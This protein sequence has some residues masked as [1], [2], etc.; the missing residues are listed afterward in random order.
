M[1]ADIR[2]LQNKIDKLNNSLNDV[3]IREIVA[4]EVLNTLKKVE[5]ITTNEDANNFKGNLLR[6]YPIV[7]S[8]FTSQE[9]GE[10]IDAIIE[11]GQRKLALEIA[12]DDFSIFKNASYGNQASI[13]IDSLHKQYSTGVENSV[14]KNFF[15]QYNS[16]N[17]FMENAERVAG[18]QPKKLVK[19]F[20]QDPQISSYYKNK[21]V[22]A[23]K[24]YKNNLPYNAKNIW[25]LVGAATISAPAMVLSGAGFAVGGML[26]LLKKGV[27]AGTYYLAKPTRDLMQKCE[28]LSLN[29]PTKGKRT[30]A[31]VGQVA[32]AIP[33]GLIE[34]VGAVTGGIL[35][36]GEYAVKIPT[37]L[38]SLP[39]VGTAKLILDGAK[40]SNDKKYDA[41]VMKIKKRVAEILNLPQDQKFVNDIFVSVAGNEKGI[42][43]S[44]VYNH[45]SKYF[46]LDFAD[47][48]NLSRKVNLQAKEGKVNLV[49]QD[50][51]ELTES[52]VD[53]VK[54]VSNVINYQ[55]P[56]N[57]IPESRPFQILV[58]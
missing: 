10:F 1:R 47:D 25:A 36:V 51:K 49:K 43:L 14:L 13:L 15:S 50:K 20:T 54:E 32:T 44:G 28:R 29:A 3:E 46:K 6:L 42:T 57:E 16:V 19:L 33:T 35:K 24:D 23:E 38:A 56:T 58:D 40:I 37:T 8:S 21:F 12:E 48:Y 26:G 27:D 55:N 30:L 2:R 53:L 39:F 31:K 11:I 45:G 52:L 41:E 17:T 22:Q 18:M 34:G 4:E 5:R 9:K 7:K